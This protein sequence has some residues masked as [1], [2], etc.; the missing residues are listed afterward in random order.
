MRRGCSLSPAGFEIARGKS[1]VWV[2]GCSPGS[3]RMSGRRFGIEAWLVGW[4]WG[5][6]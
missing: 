1:L 5:C 2:G 3:W 6:T 4:R